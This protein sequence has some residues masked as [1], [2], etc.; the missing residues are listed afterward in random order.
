MVG[1]VSGEAEGLRVLGEWT[2]PEAAK[3]GR[4]GAG[5]WG[6]PSRILLAASAGH[7]M[8]SISSWSRVGEALEGRMDFTLV[9]SVWLSR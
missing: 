1:A 8:D 5:L 2:V 7:G 3:A 6:C 4:S 9:L